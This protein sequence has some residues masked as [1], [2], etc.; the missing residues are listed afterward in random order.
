MAEYRIS[1]VWKNDINVITHY[2]VHLRTRNANGGYSIGH[3]VRMTKAEAVT[4]LQNQQNS[5]KTYLW[6]YATASWLAGGDIHVVNAN[7]PF[8]RTTHDGTVKD[9]LLHLIDYG[10]VYY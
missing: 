10:Y 8:L 6:N 4:L 3:A 5:A 7:P 9:N 2:A 1:G